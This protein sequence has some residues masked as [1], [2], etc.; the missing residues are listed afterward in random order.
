MS[1]TT[2][3]DSDAITHPEQL[4][5]PDMGQR[6]IGVECGSGIIV[7]KYKILS[8]NMY[9]IAMACQIAKKKDSIRKR[10]IYI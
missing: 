1:P 3:V 7:L 5:D 8:V 10:K 6:I 9:I 2:A 4:Q